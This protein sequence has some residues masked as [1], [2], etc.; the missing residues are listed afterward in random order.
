V[1]S[2][3]VTNPP[4]ER[5]AELLA[6]WVDAATASLH[7]PAGVGIWVVYQ[8]DYRVQIFGYEMSGIMWCAVG[9]VLGYIEPAK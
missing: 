2:S 7:R 9:V 4:T 8:S 5:P 6:P 1:R 3:A